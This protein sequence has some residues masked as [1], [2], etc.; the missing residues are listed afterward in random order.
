MDEQTTAFLKSYGLILL[1]A[2]AGIASFGFGI[3]KMQQPAEPILISQD[4]SA[5][6]SASI[7]VDIAGAV[8]K[9]GV[10]ELPSSSRI[11]DILTKAGGITDEADALF[12]AKTI[13]RAQPLVDGQKIYI[14]LKSNNEVSNT[15]GDQSE[16][17]NMN[18]ADAS[19]LDTLPGIGPATASKIIQNRPYSSLDELVEKKA[20]SKSVLEKIQDQVVVY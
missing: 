6:D 18:T 10:Y 5:S 8:A 19:L 4:E 3:F 16:L 7:I 1:L 12:V 15:L 17:I 14:P 9:P 11:S 2:I 13:N 20:V